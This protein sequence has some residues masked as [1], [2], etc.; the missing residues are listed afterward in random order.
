M[1]VKYY[2]RKQSKIQKKEP[3]LIR[4]ERRKKEPT[5]AGEN[6]GVL[7]DKEAERREDRK[8]KG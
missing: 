2:Y 3:N 8:E 7:F 6:R 4:K 1:C 5:L